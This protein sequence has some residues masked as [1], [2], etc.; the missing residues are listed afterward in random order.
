MRSVLSRLQRLRHGRALVATVKDYGRLKLNDHAA[1]LTYYAI[2]AIFPGL[3]VLVA[4]LNLFGDEGTVEGLMRIIEELA[5]G[6]ASETFEG[7]ARNAIEGSGAGFALAIG[8]AVAL[9]S[10]SNYVG[11]FNRAANDIYEVSETRPF[12][13]TIPRQIALTGLVVLVLTLALLALVLTGPLAE[14]IGGELGV[15]DAA[16]DVWKVIKWPLL[17]AVITTLFAVLLF[18]GPN[19]V[20]QSFRALFP[21]SVLAMALW[22]AASA[23][24]TVYVSNFGSYANT[25]GSIAGVIIFLI[26][27]WI[28]NLALLLGA[29][30]NVR[31]E[32][33]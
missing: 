25:Y 7:V 1:A 33:G 14:A 12:Y 31:L 4:L 22:L 18:N 17:A 32:R 30:F 8:L 21:G 23:G 24:F 29:T 26:W 27:L 20:H 9:Y 6:S 11:A 2:L 5:P 19:V 10:A 16:L 13:R 15:G 28:S 3:I